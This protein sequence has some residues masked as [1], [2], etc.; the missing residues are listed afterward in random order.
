MQAMRA[1]AKRALL[2]FTGAAIGTLR[3]DE[4]EFLQ[5]ELGRW[6]DFCQ[7]RLGAVAAVAVYL[8][9]GP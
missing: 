9:L 2:R 6:L 3:D 5:G 8:E 1:K 7:R 4:E